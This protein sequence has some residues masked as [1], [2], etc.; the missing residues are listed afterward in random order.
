[1]L[2]CISSVIQRKI[3]DKIRDSQFFGIMMDKSIDIFVLGHFVV[4]ATFLEDGVPTCVF[5]GLLHILGGK[6]DVFMIYELIP[7]SF[8][9]RWVWIWISLWILDLMGICDDE[10]SQWRGCTLKK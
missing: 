5:L 8:C 1:M 2:V 4:F 3:L 10:N 9:N 6:E 7:T